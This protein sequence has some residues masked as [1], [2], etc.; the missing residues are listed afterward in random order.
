MTSRPTTDF[1][2]FARVYRDG[3]DEEGKPKFAVFGS[4]FTPADSLYARSRIDKAPYPQWVK[5]GWL[6]AVPGE[7]IN[8]DYVVADLVD[9]AEH[10]VPVCIAYDQ[11]Y[12]HRFDEA[13]AATGKSYLTV[14]HPQGFGR[15]QKS[16]LS[17]PTSIQVLEEL[18][19]EKR[20]RVQYNPVIRLA[21]QAAKFRENPQ[22]LRFFEKRDAR[23]RIDILVAITMG[24][25][26]AAAGV[27]RVAGSPWKDEGYSIDGSTINME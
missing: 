10:C 7:N 9:H 16:G 5:D 6:H 15:S 14:E 2:G 11:R 24:L 21:V 17:M 23:S 13:L 26:A 22:M 1:T 3:Q 8:Y 19:F 27:G 25:G 4:V 20:V 12:Y 18:I